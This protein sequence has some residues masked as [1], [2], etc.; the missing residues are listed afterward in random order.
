[1]KTPPHTTTTPATTTT[2]QPPLALTSN[3]NYNKQQPLDGRMAGRQKD[4]MGFV[5]HEF[6]GI[7]PFCAGVVI[8]CVLLFVGLFLL[9]TKN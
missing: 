4:S 9:A 3:N 6:Y 7:G 1:M 5:R 2:V 8:V